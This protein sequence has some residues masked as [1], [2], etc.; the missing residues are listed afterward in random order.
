LDGLAV[1]F[2]VSVHDVDVGCVLGVDLDDG[3]QEVFETEVELLFWQFCSGL[4]FYYGGG[5]FLVV[6]VEEFVAVL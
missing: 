1:V 4:V 5:E 3:C 6:L 2:D